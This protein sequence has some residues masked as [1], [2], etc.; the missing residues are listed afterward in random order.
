MS[1]PKINPP[2]PEQSFASF[3]QWVCQAPACL[4]AHV[5]YN[6]TEHGDAAGW[7]GHHFTALCFDSFGRRCRQG[8]DF[9]RARD[10]DAFPVWWVWPDQ[11]VD[12][13]GMPA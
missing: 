12:L 4:T 2:F 5:E 6:N 3:A 7:R 13:I 10:E 9:M 11:V 8:S 1:E